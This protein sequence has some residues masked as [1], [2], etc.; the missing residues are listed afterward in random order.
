LVG[1]GTSATVA[2]SDG[3]AAL[4]AFASTLF[5]EV[6]AEHDIVREQ[7][8]HPLRAASPWV[9]LHPAVTDDELARFNPDEAVAVCDLAKRLTG[10]DCAPTGPIAD[11]VA[12]VLSG[13][14]IVEAIEEACEGPRAL[15][16]VARRVQ[17]RVDSRRHLAEA[18]VTREVEAYLLVG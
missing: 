12:A 13:N 14:A 10:R 15:A 2:G 3:G 7:L 16:E 17:E 1:I 5:G 18:A 6:V 9:P 8:V 4:A 11:R